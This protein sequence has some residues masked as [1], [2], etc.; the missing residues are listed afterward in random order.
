VLSQVIP[1]RALSADET[2]EMLDP[3][4]DALSYLHTKGFVHG[5]LKPSNVLV[6]DNQLKLSTDS[7]LFSGETLN[8]Q[9]TQ[10]SSD[11]PL[12]G[13][14]TITPAMDVWSLGITI[15]EA[16]TQHPPEWNK[17]N[18]RA[19]VVPESVPKPFS[20]IAMRCLQL[21]PASRCTLSDV[22]SLL[23][24]NGG[25]YHGPIQHLP[26]DAHK[27]S[28]RAPFKIPVLWMIVAFLALIAI[29]AVMNLRSRM[30]QSV[31]PSESS[32]QLSSAPSLPQ[33]SPAE[34][35]RGSVEKGAVL[36][37]VLP[38]VPRHAAESIRGTVKVVVRVT[39]DA[40]GGVTEATLA[41]PGPSK[42]FARMA[43]ESAQSWKFKPAQADGHA[44][45]S[46]WRLQYQ[47]RS[48]GIEVTPLEES[49]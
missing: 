15:I 39:V 22:K 30:Q 35:P 2:R 37:R 20:Q 40:S 12:D 16:L 13:S 46:V 25:S 18:G 17:S 27:F 36:G 10:G 1:E 11:G 49:P 33:Q 24:G 9:P 45:P 8:R 41:S 19:P 3:I 47:F 21:D 14:G 26:G 31:M 7:L 38:G 4:I 34:V 6:V 43:Q 28:K 48:S 42:Y 5:H 44:V 29:I 32:G 23:A